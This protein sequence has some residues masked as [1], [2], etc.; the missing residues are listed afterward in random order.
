MAEA[1]A[2]ACFKVISCMTY[3]SEMLDDFQRTIRLYVPEGRTFNKQDVLVLHVQIHI[4]PIQCPVTQIE[5]LFFPYSEY[6]ML[7]RS[8]LDIFNGKPDD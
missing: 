7:L 1:V 6:Q 5:G 8:S 2:S 4:Y 3:S